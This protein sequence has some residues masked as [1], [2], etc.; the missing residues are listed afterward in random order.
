MLGKTYDDVI[1]FE[2]K[3]AEVLEGIE[4]DMPVRQLKDKKVK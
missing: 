3:L 2:T 1:N 4:E